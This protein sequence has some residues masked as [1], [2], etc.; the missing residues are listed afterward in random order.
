MALV[1]TEYFAED[2]VEE[3]Y[4]HTI[5]G[6]VVERFDLSTK[7]VYL[8][9]G[10]RSYHPTDDI[11]P[12]MRFFRRNDITLRVMDTFLEAQGNVYKGT[13]D[14]GAAHYTGRLAVFKHGWRV[15]PEDVN[16]TLTVTGE[17]ITDDGQSGAAIMDTSGLSSNIIIN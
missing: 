7:L 3:D 15:V 12:E 10:V 9:E 16:H 1:K 17:Q 2:F 4:A 8:A 13:D 14:Q 11:Y 6:G 5:S